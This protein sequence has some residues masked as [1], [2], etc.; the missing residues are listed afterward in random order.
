MTAVTAI[1]TKG[2]TR[3][4]GA[5][6][7]TDGVDYEVPTGTVSARSG[8]TGAGKTTRLSLLSGYLKPTAG[9]GTVLGRPMG[10][11][12]ALKGRLGVYP[13]DAALDPRRPVVAQ[14]ALWAE[15]SGLSRSQAVAE[16]RRA[17]DSVDL[18][19]RADDPAGRLSHGMARRAG[20]AGAL[21]G[22]PDLVLLDEPTA[23]LDPR[24]GHEVRELIAG[25]RGRV[26][27]VV[28][29]HNLAEL[30]A[31]C[32]HATI[33]D[34][35]RIV[36]QGPLD[37]LTRAGAEVRVEL[38]GPPPDL[39]P[40]TALPRVLDARE[41]EEPEVLVVEFDTADGTPAEEPLA[42]VLRHL[43]DAG[44]LVREVRRGRSLERRFLE[45]TGVAGE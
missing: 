17:L 36:A 34:H 6:V 11:V 15:L 20:L 5:L 37:E 43:L 41:G 21:L 40:L 3:R 2:L 22:S 42:A 13:Q 45:L 19:D 35:G 31:I 33:L 24:V 26:T 18:A 38:A 23:G 39:A 44:A 30:Q 4:F 25:L 12:A 14:L 28:S 29:S 8:P 16:A 7:A 10:D 27:A 9:S 32:D 1:S